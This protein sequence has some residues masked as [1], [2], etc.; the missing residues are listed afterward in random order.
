MFRK[1][2]MLCVS[3]ALAMAFWISSAYA[4]VEDELAPCP[5]CGAEYAFEYV[6]TDQY[7]DGL[8]HHEYVS[9]S[10]CR[11]ILPLVCSNCGHKDEVI[12][13]HPHD[14]GY[15]YEEGEPIDSSRHKFTS[16]ETCVWCQHQF[17]EEN[18]GKHSYSW[19]KSGNKMVY[20]CSECK[21]IAKTD[22]LAN[23]LT[24]KGKKV[25]VKYE[26]LKKKAKT[27]RRAKVLTVNNP[28]GTVTYAKVKGNKKITISKKTGK[29]TV[30]KGLK[31][32]TYKVTVKVTASGN[33]IYKKM[34]RKATVTI[35]VK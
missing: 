26:A 24:V 35:K 18:Y 4:A 7:G 6:E 32:G 31:K 28:K 13:D 14:F 22:K 20:Q 5:Q 25:T 34:A 12:T 16:Y 27:F 33:G 3:I 15:T 29:V 10:V 2:I 11:Q 19:V 1:T 30:K 17:V 21:Y 8:S 9:D 23:T